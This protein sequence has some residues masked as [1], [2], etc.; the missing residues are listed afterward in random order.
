VLVGLPRRGELVEADLHRGQRGS[1]VG[2]QIAAAR[3]FVDDRERDLV[4]RVV[5]LDEA[6]DRDA[7]P[8]WA[9]V[10]KRGLDQVDAKVE[11]GRVLD[12]AVAVVGH[13]AVRAVVGGQ[14]GRD[15]LHRLAGEGRRNAVDRR[16]A[17]SVPKIGPGA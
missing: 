16:G 4:V 2:S 7:A 5:E 9:E 1:R 15:P 10:L 12:A 13:D 6:L 14:R 3:P 17:S 11:V 8:V